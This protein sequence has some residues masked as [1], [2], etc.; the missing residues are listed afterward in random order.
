MNSRHWPCSAKNMAKWINFAQCAE[1]YAHPSWR[2]QD[3]ADGKICSA[4]KALRNNEDP[5]VWQDV[6]CRSAPV[7]WVVDV[8]QHPHA[9]AQFAAV[10]GI[11]ETDAE[12]DAVYAGTLSR[13]IAADVICYRPLLR[14]Q[15]AP[16]P[17]MCS[18]DTLGYRILVAAA[19]ELPCAVGARLRLLA[20]TALQGDP[21]FPAEHG[22][23]WWPLIMRVWRWGRRTC[24]W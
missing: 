8:A 14:S 18:M 23:S 22:V 19:Q 7:K 21:Y 6:D 15:R 9:V 10:L 13:A 5:A 24:L 4:R 12:D 17:A 1:K 2:S 3:V 11:V 20:P 16:A